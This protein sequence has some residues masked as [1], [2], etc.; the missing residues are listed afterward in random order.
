MPGRRRAGGGAQGAAGEAEQ[1]IWPT[2]TPL[3]YTNIT[4]PSGKKATA[5]DPQVAPIVSK[6]FEWYA[7]GRYS[8]QEISDPQEER[9]QCAA[10]SGLAGG[11]GFEPIFP[12]T[13]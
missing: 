5:A 2:K 8:L 10:A 9:K 11:P 3:G 1:G 13:A 6:L 7:A 4:E 12:L